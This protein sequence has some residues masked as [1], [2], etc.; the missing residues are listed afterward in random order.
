VK[1]S[2]VVRELQSAEVA[3]SVGDVT[4]KWPCCVCEEDLESV[5]SLHYRQMCYHTT[6]ELS[7]A[8]LTL[9]GHKLLAQDLEEAPDSEDAVLC[10][11]LAKYPH[12]LLNKL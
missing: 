11:G 8:V 4:H 1:G 10:T 7:L 6:E 9:K 5:S 2:N 3:P 12:F